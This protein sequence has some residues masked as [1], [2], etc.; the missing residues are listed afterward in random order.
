MI[1]VLAQNGKTRFGQAMTPDAAADVQLEIG[2]VLFMDM[3]GYSQLLI[4]EQSELQRKLNEIV[5][6]TQQ[7]RAAEAAGKL[8]CIP[9]GDGMAVVFFNSL[10]APLRC[11]IE[12]VQALNEHAPIRL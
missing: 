5:R 6:A 3:V 10:E 1:A 7:F 8:V 4:D 11:A 2:H 12:I 9:T